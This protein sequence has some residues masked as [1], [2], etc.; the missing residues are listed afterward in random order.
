[1]KGKLHVVERNEAVRV[2][3][4]GSQEK[5][6]K[7]KEKRRRDSFLHLYSGPALP[8]PF[9][10]LSAISFFPSCLS[11]FPPNLLSA[12]IFAACPFLSPLLFFLR[13]S[14]FSPLCSKETPLCI[15]PSLIVIL[16]KK[17]LKKGFYVGTLLQSTKNSVQI[18]WLI[19]FALRTIRT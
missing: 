8:P 14:D 15:I 11:H 9:S 18:W 12:S 6:N 19:F 4:R 5:E 7:A 13:Q 17:R 16:S 1:M 3:H 2:Y 10:L